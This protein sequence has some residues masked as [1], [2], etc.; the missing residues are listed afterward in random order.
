MLAKQALIDLGIVLLVPVLVV[1]GYLL[2]GNGGESALLSATPNANLSPD[3]P[4]AKTKLA[5]DTLSGITLTDALFKDEA[6][7]SLTAFT[8]TIPQV[9]LSR[10]YPFTP[11]AIIE[12]KLRQA[13]LGI[14]ASK[15]DTAAAK[16]TQSASTP[17]LS[18]KIDDLK[19]SVVGK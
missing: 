10:D 15:T 3:M 8:V 2:W 14:S 9:E 18:K 16:G 17:N 19:K 12:E 1:G 6:F 4:G 7:T 5:L 11:P 13:R